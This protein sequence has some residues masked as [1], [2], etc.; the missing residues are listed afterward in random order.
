MSVR[1]EIAERLFLHG[2]QTV[3]DLL[4]PYIKEIQ[5][6]PKNVP[7]RDMLINRWNTLSVSTAIS[8][9]GI[10]RDQELLDIIANKE[11]RKTVRV[12]L[13]KNKALHPVTRMFLYQESLKSNDYD[14]KNAVEMGITPDE[15]LLYL[16]DDNIR[17]NQRRF[18]YVYEHIVKNED[19]DILKKYKKNLQPELLSKIINGIINTNPEKAFQMLKEV[20]IDISK[21][22]VTL[23]IQRLPLQSIET[24]KKLYKIDKEGCKNILLQSFRDEPEKIIE[25]DD[26]LFDEIISYRNYELPIIKLFFSKNRLS[27]LFKNNPRFSDEAIKYIVENTSDKY[28]LSRTIIQSDYNIAGFEKISDYSYFIATNLKYEKVNKI[29]SWINSNSKY[30]GLD[31]TIELIDQLSIH[32]AKNEFELTYRNINDL[33]EEFKIDNDTFINKLSD[34]SI[35]RIQKFPK[36]SNLITLLQRAKNIS[37]ELYLR[38]ATSII[39]SD[40]DLPKKEFDEIIEITIKNKNFDLFFNILG[41]ADKELSISNIIKYKD[42]ISNE[43][44][45]SRDN[46]RTQWIDYV[47]D[48]VKPQ[49]GW[50]NIRSQSINRAAISYLENNLKDDKA[51]WESVLCLYEGWS[52]TLQE[53]VDISGKI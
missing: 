10:I 52:G 41:R 50:G 17:F 39:N 27:D 5:G 44:I 18:E 38:V 9:V 25:I 53:L 34:K 36:V 40:Q 15:L 14:L 20:D 24:Y 35:I 19:L 13:A 6:T 43:I 32:E 46:D 1:K 8:F 16:S 30:I 26:N 3:T 29:I 7:S 49:S 51:K 12:A 48:T 37:E 22:E 4:F 28:I 45:N 47:I 31:K 33:V 2:N 42:I 11:K 23:N 21:F